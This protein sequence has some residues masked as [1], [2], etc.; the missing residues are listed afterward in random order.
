MFKV[1]SIAILKFGSDL[2]FAN[3]RVY[4]DFGGEGDSTLKRRM[5]YSSQ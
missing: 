5:S 4:A 1:A 3:E 2:K